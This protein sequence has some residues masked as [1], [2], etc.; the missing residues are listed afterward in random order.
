M[1]YD[2]YDDPPRGRYGAHTIQCAQCGTSCGTYYEAQLSG[3]PEDCSPAEYG[4][5][6]EVTDAEGNE[7]CSQECSDEYHGIDEENEDD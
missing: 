3:P 6:P 7:F 2:P 4:E 1:S 5:E